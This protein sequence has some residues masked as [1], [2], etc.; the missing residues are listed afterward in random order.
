MAFWSREMWQSVV[1][2]AIELL[3]SGHLGLHFYTAFATKLL[4]YTVQ[5]YLS[6]REMN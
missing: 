1:D 2:R 6:V 3:A 4:A 5:E